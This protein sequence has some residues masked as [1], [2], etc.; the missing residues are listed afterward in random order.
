MM[1]HLQLNGS[2]MIMAEVEVDE[3]DGKRE[4]SRYVF[5]E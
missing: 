2:D 1:P 5:T 3:V 4:G